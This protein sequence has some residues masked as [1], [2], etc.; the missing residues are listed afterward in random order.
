MEKISAGLHLNRGK[1]RLM[2]LSL[3]NKKIILQSYSRLWDIHSYKVVLFHARS[4]AKTIFEGKCVV[5]VQYSSDTN[6]TNL[7]EN[8][9]TVPQKNSEPENILVFLLGL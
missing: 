9:E 6:F 8:E 7:E 5:F 2:S 4:H 1:I 3:L